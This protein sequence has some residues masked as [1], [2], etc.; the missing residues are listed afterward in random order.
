MSDNSTAVACIRNQ[1]TQRSV[2]LLNLSRKLLEFCEAQN[3]TPIPKH[4]PGKFNVLAVQTEWSLDQATFNHLWK[5]HGPFGCDLFATRFNRQLE[6]FISPFPDPLAQG[7]NAMSIQWDQW[8]SIYLFPSIPLLNEVI[9]RLFSFKG[10]GILIAPNIQ[11]RL[12]SRIF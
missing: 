6:S 4:L 11:R 2:S 10:K 8:D 5:R 7:I 1:G 12:G 3:I 9:T